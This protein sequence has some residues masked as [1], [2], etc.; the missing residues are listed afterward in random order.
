MMQIP[1]KEKSLGVRTNQIKEYRIILMGLSI[2][3]GDP[4]FKARKYSM[5]GG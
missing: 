1:I 4:S 5:G 2:R 3:V